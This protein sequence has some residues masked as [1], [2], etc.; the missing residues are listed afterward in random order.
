MPEPCHV[1]HGADFVKVSSY[2]VACPRCYKEI[3]AAILGH[4][5]A[6]S[7]LSTPVTLANTGTFLLSRSK[8]K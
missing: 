3:N 4:V 1:C 6:A 8:G 2:S 7:V 5:I